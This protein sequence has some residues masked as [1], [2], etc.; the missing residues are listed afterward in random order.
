MKT[1]LHITLL[2][3][4]SFSFCQEDKK[5]Q[6]V[7]GARS[8]IYNSNFVSS[9]D[10]TTPPK[11]SGGYALIDLG[12]KIKPNSNT[13]ILGMM[14]IR[15]DFG[16]FWGAGVSF[17]V[18]QL[19][20]RGVAA[21]ILRY[22]IG[23]IDYK[24]TP[25]TFYNHNS[26]ALTRSGGV[27]K[28][29]EDIIN[30]E[31]FYKKN[32]WRQQGASV[33]FIIESPKVVDD[34]EFKG[35]ITRLNP[36]NSSTI[37]DQA[38]GG[39]SVIFSKKNFLKV[40]FNHSNIFDVK[41][42]GIDSN[43]YNNNVSSITYN[44]FHQKK[45]YKIGLEGESGMSYLSY[46][47]YIN[48][49]YE[50]YFLNF[51]GYL[52]S[53]NDQFNFYLGFMDN[54]PD[55]RSFGA[56]S[57]R[58]D[59]NQDNNFYKRYSNDQILRPL[60]MYDLYNDP[61]LYK[62]GITTG[63]MMYNPSFSNVLPYGIT[64]FNRRGIYY[65]TSIKDINQVVEVSHQTYLLSEIRGQGTT[66]LKKF[67]KSDLNID[68]NINKVLKLKRTFKTSVGAVYQKTDRSGDFDFQKV[69][70]SSLILNLCIE[71]EV[72][73]DFFLISNFFLIQSNGTDQLPDRDKFGKI[74][75]YKE[76]SVNGE[77]YTLSAGVR[78]D[79]S[80]KIYLAAFYELNTNRF[81]AIPYT[82]NQASI[83]YVMKF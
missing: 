59:F 52:K 55:F 26:D 14:R 60:S 29:K 23:N 11:S 79:F 5:I 83:F 33:N 48:E 8:Q 3:M 45:K 47:E 73:K 12:V 58:I 10:T 21:N 67:I 57:K 27:M 7:G 34:I 32:S 9:G 1:F 15:N 62:N 81:N 24:L 13:E 72:L 63:E 56:Q 41:G 71:K 82:Y 35:F 37:L 53:L 54:G 44:I 25:Y 76:Y 39:G 42:T 40:G 43:I 4:T 17:D 69:D 18:R 78:F 65:S 46:G 22:Q 51:R 2:L 66:N 75:N 16:G 30:Y 70:L 20:L 38:F 74:L 19:Y 77:E 31:S 68:F 28:I 61:N 36:S 64:T 49:K 6:Y 80:Q 50:D